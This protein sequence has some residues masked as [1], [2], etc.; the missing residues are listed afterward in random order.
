MH[1]EIMG[2]GFE[3]LAN[4]FYA[5]RVLKKRRAIIGGVAIFEENALDEDEFLSEW[6]TLIQMSLHFPLLTPKTVLAHYSPQ[7]SVGVSRYLRS[8]VRIKAFL[9]VSKSNPSI[10]SCAR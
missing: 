1:L 4:F 10:A 8:L 2:N 3:N 9:A 6:L 7:C 5:F